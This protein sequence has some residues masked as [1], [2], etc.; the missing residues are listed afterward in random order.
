[1]YLISELFRLVLDRA[2]QKERSYAP[3]APGYATG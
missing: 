2:S 1:L 3:S